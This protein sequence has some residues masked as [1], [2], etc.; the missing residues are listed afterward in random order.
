MLVVKLLYNQVVWD[1]RPEDG[2]QGRKMLGL[3]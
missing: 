1:E 2:F 3:V